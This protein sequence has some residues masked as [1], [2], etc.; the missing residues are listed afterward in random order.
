MLRIIAPR[1]YEDDSGTVR[2][3]DIC[4]DSGRVKQSEFC[5]SIERPWRD[6]APNVSRVPNGTYS[7][8]PWV[9]PSR[10]PVWALIGGTVSPYI[11]DVPDRAKRWGVLIH[12]ANYPFNVEGCLGL[13]SSYAEESDK[14]GPA[15]WSSTKTID[16]WRNLVHSESHIILSLPE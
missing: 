14:G 9:S 8:V 1:I 3:W 6:N 16:L 5:Y 12:I 10:G 7:V 15:V 13:G 4:D 11:E 2:R